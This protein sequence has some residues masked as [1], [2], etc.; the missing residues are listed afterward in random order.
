[1][2][3]SLDTVALA[4][5]DLPAARAFYTTALAPTATD[6]GHAIDL[7]LPGAGRFS[8]TEA[9]TLAATAGVAPSTDGFRGF[10]LTYILTQPTEVSAVMAG[11]VQHGAELLKPAKK[12][13]FGSFSG[14][15]RTPDGAVWK[16]AASS[17][18]DT[19][20]AATSP[21]PTETTLILGVAD[22]KVSKAFYAALGMTVDRDYGGKYVDFRP[23]DG[24]TRLCLMQR[25]ALAKDAGVSPDGGGFPGMVLDHRAGSPAEVDAL[26]AAAER[27]GGRVTAPAASTGHGAAGHFADPDGFLWRVAS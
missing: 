18:K 3:L 26:L 4:T 23:A 22:V 16:L 13:L 12:A 21:Q 27:G 20:P 6:R 2:N 9:G 7:D 15:L 10:V 17:G 8:L 14:A 1:M 19:G 24:A 25:G 11:A 5:P